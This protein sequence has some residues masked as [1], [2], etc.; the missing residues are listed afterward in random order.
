MKLKTW[1]IV[2]LVA[3]GQVSVPGAARA[4]DFG[5]TPSNVFG[6]WSNI[7]GALLVFAEQTA[8]GRAAELAAMTPAPAQGKVPGDVLGRVVEFRDL[9]E[10]LRGQ[11]GLGPIDRHQP[12]AP[13][14]PTDVYLNSSAVMKGLV[15]TLIVNTNPE[16][17]ISRLYDDAVFEGKTPSDVFGMVDLAIRRLRAM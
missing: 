17:K 14:T 6:M 9:L 15:Q 16:V 12:S 3:A 10:R 5:V 13:V 11:H 1:I 7:N 8:P 4:V 2:F